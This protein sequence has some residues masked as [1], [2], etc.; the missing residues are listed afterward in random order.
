MWHLIN[1]RLFHAYIKKTCKVSSKCVK[2]LENFS[3]VLSV[4]N[5]SW[6]GTHA[7]E[8]LHVFHSNLKGLR[9]EMNNF[10]KAFCPVT[11]FKLHIAA[12]LTP[13]MLTG[14]RL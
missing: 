8:G 5:R 12:I 6:P 13:T 2:H 10:L 4:G 7:F 11:R 3:V 1:S 9:H 14:S